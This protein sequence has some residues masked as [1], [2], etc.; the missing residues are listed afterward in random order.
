MDGS[1]GLLLDADDP[2]VALLVARDLGGAIRHAC[3]GRAEL[4]ANIVSEGLEGLGVDLEGLGVGVILDVNHGV[5]DRHL[6]S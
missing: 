3:D 2:E 1:V 4:H 6:D 5:I